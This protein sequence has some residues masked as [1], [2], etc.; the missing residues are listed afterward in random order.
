MEEENRNPI[1]AYIEKILKKTGNKKIILFGCGKTGEKIYSYLK[2]MKKPVAYF[3]D[4]ADEKQGT[5]PYGLDVKTIY[6]LLYED[7]YVLFLCINEEVETAKIELDNIGLIED[8]D[9]FDVARFWRRQE[10]EGIIDCFC[11][12][13]WASDMDGFKYW[14]NDA[15]SH[16]LMILG[17]ST[18][19]PTYTVFP[20]WGYYFYEMLEEKYPSDVIVYNGAVIGYNSSQA[21]LKLLRDGLTLRPEIVI[22][23]TGVND[24]F[25][26]T[27]SDYPMVSGYMQ[28]VLSKLFAENNHKGVF[29]SMELKERRMRSTQRCSFGL[30]SRRDGIDNWI[31][32]LRIMHAI[33]SEFGISYYAFLQPTSITGNSG[34]MIM[35]R[36]NDFMFSP[37]TIRNRRNLYL[38]ARNISQ[39]YDYIYDITDAFE[40]VAGAVYCDT[41]HYTEYGNKILAEKI[42]NTVL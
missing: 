38:R 7:A 22:D 8:K 25:N 24:V 1:I 36:L 30:P 12:F 40:E 42:F 32:N 10:G 20:S 41:V 15:A 6:D 3:V 11:G 23:L 21:L 34:D 5:K 4:N 26:K 39:K 28:Y 19:D 17:G 18:S 35:N 14:G 16:R 2:I 37:Q 29:C 13:S 31:N 33:C 9:Y 27:T